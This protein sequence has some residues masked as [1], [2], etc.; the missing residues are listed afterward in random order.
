MAEVGTKRSP[1]YLA[2]YEGLRS[3]YFATVGT[4][5]AVGSLFKNLV[6]AGRVPA[7]ISGPVGIFLFVGEVKSL[8]LVYLLQFIAILSVNLAVLNILPIPAL[9]GGRILFLVIERLI[10]SK[11]NPKV[12]NA[13]H[14]A[15][16][17]ILILLMIIITYRDIIKLF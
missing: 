8:G 3:V 1:W 5:S 12:E 16:F 15:G 6:F 13:I 10:Q 9:D 14:T 11:F 4:I 7:E 2:P 17:L